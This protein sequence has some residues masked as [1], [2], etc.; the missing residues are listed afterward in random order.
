VGG[1][2]S[3]ATAAAAPDGS[4]GTKEQD[5]DRNKIN[6]SIWYRNYKL[7]HATHSSQAMPRDVTLSDIRGSKVSQ[8]ALLF[9]SSD[10]GSLYYNDDAQYFETR[11]V[12]LSEYLWFDFLKGRVVVIVIDNESSQGSL[13]RGCSSNEHYNMI[14]GDIWSVISQSGSFPWL[15]RV[16]SRLNI[17]DIPS[18]GRSIVDL[19]TFALEVSIDDVARRLQ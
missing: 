3:A 14:V 1:P 7:A 11:A 9:F 12:L 8:T 6:R 16:V 19:V 18:R 5:T 13:C 17:A 2:S 15:A 10:L 4:P